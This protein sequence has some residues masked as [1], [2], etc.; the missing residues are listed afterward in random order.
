MSESSTTPAE[1]E[2]TRINKYLVFC[3]YESR[4]KADKLIADGVVEINGQR[5]EAG[6]RVAPGDFVKVNGK[7]ARPKAQVTLLLNKP[8]RFVCSRVP[9]GAEGTVYDLIPP[10]YRH[11]N[12]VGRLDENSEGLLLLTSK[13]EF[14]EHVTQP[15]SGIEKEYWVTL[16]QSYDNESL[17]QLLKG[18]RIPEGHAKA[19]YVGR[20]SSRRACVV[21]EQGMKRQIRQMFACVGLHVRKLVRVRI[22]SLWGGDLQPGHLIVLTEE[23]EKMVL[24]NPKRRKGLINASMAFPASGK[25]NA[26]QLSTQLDVQTARDALKEEADYQF[27]PDDF[28][29]EDEAAIAAFTGHDDEDDIAL[30]PSRFGNRPRPNAHGRGIQ[31][32]RSRSFGDRSGAPYRSRRPDSARFGANKADRH[33]SRPSYRPHDSRRSRHEYSEGEYNSSRSPQKYEKRRQ[34]DRPRYSSGRGFNKSARYD[35]HGDSPHRGKFH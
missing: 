30:R 34:G 14:N 17:V 25:L 2:G 16:N 32:P 5:A 1:Q 22:G 13:G 35:R 24:T 28:E 33:G 4:R 8:R 15:R 7:L 18:V 9:Q 11:T 21:L 6:A 23:Q 27:N 26:D 20:L 31:R 12:Y 3:G 10:K 19:K 29:S